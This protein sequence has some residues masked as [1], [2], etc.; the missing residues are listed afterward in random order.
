M[1]VVFAFD[2]VRFAL[3][4]DQIDRFFDFGYFFDFDYSAGSDLDCPYFD[5][6]GLFYR[7]CYL[8]CLCCPLVFG[9]LV[10]L[11]SVL[12]PS[13]LVVDLCFVDLDFVRP[14]FDPD[15]VVADFLLKIFCL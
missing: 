10:C 2:F 11:Y 15:F 6:A 8:C 14:Y 7:L 5:L 4:F 1:K 3:Y 9:R 12:D 13:D